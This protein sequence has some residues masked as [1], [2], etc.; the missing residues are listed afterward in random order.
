M[1][2][3][4]NKQFLWSWNAEKREHGGIGNEFVFAGQYSVTYEE[5][6]ESESAQACIVVTRYDYKID[7]LSCF[8][9]F[10]LWL[11]CKEKNLFMYDVLYILRNTLNTYK[12]A[13]AIIP[14]AID[15][16]TIQA[17]EIKPA[18]RR[19]GPSVSIPMESHVKRKKHTSHDDI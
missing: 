8:A 3:D 4:A 13:Q 16:H 2:S 18:T 12:F 11:F 9:G 6:L 17:R 10:F 7:F 14:F 19:F 5:L 1:F 15:T